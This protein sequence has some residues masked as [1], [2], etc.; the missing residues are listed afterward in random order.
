MQAWKEIIYTEI[1]HQYGEEGKGTIAM[2]MTWLGKPAQTLLV[3]RQCVEH[4]GDLEQTN[5]MQEVLTKFSNEIP[6]F[7]LKGNT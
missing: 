2:E 7:F 6:K 5:F 3:Q 1:G 4:H